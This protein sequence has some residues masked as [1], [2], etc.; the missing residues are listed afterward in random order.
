MNIVNKLS[1]IAFAL[2]FL[3]GAG[4]QA[5]SLQEGQKALEQDKFDQ[6]RNIF[7]AV[8]QKEPANAAAD[9]YLGLIQVKSDQLDSALFF[10]NKGISMNAEEPL[11]YVGLGRVELLR[12]DAQNAKQ[13]FDKALDLTKKNSFVMQQIADAYYEAYMQQGVNYDGEYAASL[14]QKAVKM[15][16]QNAA[17]GVTLGDIYRVQGDGG[18]AMTQYTNIGSTLNSPLA[19]VRAGELMAKVKNFDAAKSNYEKALAI[20]NNFPPAYRDMGELYFNTNKVDQAIQNYKKYLD[21]VGYSPMQRLRYAG[22]LYINKDYQQSLDELLQVKDILPGNPIIYRLLGY[23]YYETGDSVKALQAMQDFFSHAKSSDIAGL[24]YIYYGKILN[25][26]GKTAESIQYARKALR[27]DSS[28]KDLYDQ[29]AQSY[30]NLK[31]Y[32]SAAAILQQKIAHSN[33]PSTQDLYY[34]GVYY[35][36]AKDY[37]NTDTAFARLIHLVPDYA[38]S[39]LFRARANLALDPSADKTQAKTWYEQFIPK[40]QGNPQQNKDGL[41]EAYS[42][43]G[44]YY[45]KQKQYDQAKE[46]YNKTLALDPGNKDALTILKA[47][48]AIRAQK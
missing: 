24:D 47:I 15:E 1:R 41:I 44:Y 3:L 29:L 23:D 19:Y 20:D 39:Y 18:Q 7:A 42:F 36:Q 2:F 12:K 26:L 38:T 11:N 4:A 34:M 40:A 13:N 43:L 10:F 22:F 14:I 30:A 35:Y 46:Y 21:L 16:P 6:A 45:Y 31:E 32:D 8:L 37:K 28:N 25:K 48:S 5:Q 33:G 17:Y 27:E 9:Y